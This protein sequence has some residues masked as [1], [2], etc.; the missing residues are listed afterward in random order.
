MPSCS[1]N[2]RNLWWLSSNSSCPFL[3]TWGDGFGHFPDLIFRIVIISNLFWVMLASIKMWKPEA[4]PRQYITITKELEQQK[5]ANLEGVAWSCVYRGQ[6]HT[7]SYWRG[8][9]ILWGKQF[10][11]FLLLTNR[12]Q[13]R[14][15]EALHQTVIWIL[16]RSLQQWWPSPKS[17]IL[18]DDRNILGGF[19][20]MV[21]SSFGIFFRLL[22]NSLSLHRRRSTMDWDGIV[23]V[24]FSCHGLIEVTFHK[25]FWTCLAVF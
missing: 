17:W 3:H 7:I 11:Q 8:S 21:W 9:P 19:N 12:I 22:A 1:W 6:D 25:T 18:A 23:L 16:R 5:S 10:S 2:S 4:P 15:L 13:Y 20:K 14:C 24:T